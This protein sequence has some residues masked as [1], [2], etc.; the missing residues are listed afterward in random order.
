MKDA[1]RPGNRLVQFDVRKAQDDANLILSKND[2]C[3]A[4][5]LITEQGEA[6]LPYCL[7]NLL[8]LSLRDEGNE[9]IELTR[10]L[11]NQFIGHSH[12]Y[13]TF[14]LEADLDYLDL[15]DQVH[16][17]TQRVTDQLLY[18]MRNKVAKDPV[19]AYLDAYIPIMNDEFNDEVVYRDQ[20]MYSLVWENACLAVG[21]RIMERLFLQPGRLRLTF[22]DG[23]PDP[24]LAGEYANHEVT[25]LLLDAFE[26][27]DLTNCIFTEQIILAP[28]LSHVSSQMQRPLDQVEAHY[29]MMFSDLIEVYPAFL[30]EE[31]FTFRL[32]DS[33]QTL[34]LLFAPAHGVAV[35]TASRGD[36]FPPALTFDWDAQLV[37]HGQPWRKV[38][39]IYGREAYLRTA[40][41][42]L[43]QIHG[44]LV[45]RYLDHQTAMQ[46]TSA[47]AA[48]VSHDA[49]PGPAHEHAMRMEWVREARREAIPPVEPG[50]DD[51]PLSRGA[52]PQIR[53]SL[54]FKILKSC[55]V[56]IEQGKGSEIK[57]LREGKHPFRLGNHGF[58][59]PTVPTW[60]AA[61][62]LRRLEIT[63]R[64]WQSAYSAL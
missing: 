44:E 61:V 49:E 34:D 63:K 10:Q 8:P 40:C 38:E 36:T 19:R 59:N 35:L 22:R 23:D 25:S 39:S 1:G 20:S 55:G 64:E 27:W 13:V 43:E 54:F 52:I 47:I 58:V 57:L 9:L 51:E 28:I 12:S 21:F 6:R 37:F 17:W 31:M 26:K 2:L 14:L 53:R 7:A 60:L 48:E 18:K 56:R 50:E 11:N 3:L 41:W 42:V 46:T 32:P 15:R 30:M 33:T 45:Q 16:D 5:W 62:I 24:E 4:D 29:R